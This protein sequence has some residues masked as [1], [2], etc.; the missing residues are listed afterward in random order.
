LACISLAAG[1]A[2]GAEEPVS[3]FISTA[4]SL[5]RAEDDAALA[6]HIEQHPLLVGAAVADLLDRAARAPGSFAGAPGLARRIARYY[7][8]AGG[9]LTCLSLVETFASWSP[10]DRA[11]RED[12]RVQH[13]RAD[14]LRAS[15]PA[16]ALELY[17]QIIP[18]YES[19]G[20][21]HAIA[22]AWGGI[23]VAQWYLG[24]LGQVQEA[25][26][27]ALAARRAVEDHILEGKTLNG[28]GSVSLQTGRLSEAVR[29]YS[30]AIALRRRTGDVSGLGTSLTYLG[31]AYYKMGRLAD[32]REE[33]L[34][35]LP[36]LE[37][38]GSPGQRVDLLNG[39][40]NCDSE[41][42]RYHRANERYREAAEIARAAGALAKEARCRV[43]LADSYQRTGR[44]ARALA[45]LDRVDSLVAV[46]HDPE[47]PAL[48]HSTRGQIN[49]DIGAL[50][51]ARGDFLAGVE[52]AEGL[53]DPRHLMDALINLAFLYG[54]LGAT[55]RGLETAERA[56]ALAEKHGN[57]R[58]Y[59]NAVVIAANLLYRAGDAE[60]ALER[61]E[62]AL[63]LDRFEKMAAQVLEDRISIA[64]I[65]AAL[66]RP[67][68]SQQLFYQLAPEVTTPRLEVSFHLGL[69]H[70]FERLD[71][72]SATWHYEKALSV[73]EDSR[74]QLG[75]GEARSSFLSGGRR[76]YFEE[77][78]RYYATRDDG[79]DGPW[80]ER[81]FRTIER[82]KARGLLELM[83]PA[84]ESDDAPLDR[85]NVQPG[86][87]IATVADVRVGLPQGAAMLQYALGD[88]AS[89]LWVVDEGGHHLEFLPPRRRIATAV[90]QFRDAVRRPGAG[91]PTLRAA[92]RSLYDMLV[93]PVAR[94]LEN[95]E[96]VVIVPDGLL[97]GVP[98]D[99]LLT[100]DSEG[101]WRTQPFLG[102]EWTTVYSPSA[103]VYFQ[104]ANNEVGETSPYGADLVALGD[105]EFSSPALAPLP[106][107]RAEVGA[108]AEF[109]DA[110]RREVW[111]GGEAT[112]AR[113][114]D[115]LT[116]VHPR[117]LHFATHGI[118]DA[119][120]PQR[121]EIVLCA[122]D[123]GRFDGHL[124]MDE[125][126]ATSGRAGLVVLSACESGLGKVS[127]GEG[128]IGLSRA[129]I[130]AGCGGTVASLWPVADESTGRLM[131]A[132][133]REML[134]AQQPAARAMRSA[135]LSLLSD[136]TYAH[137]FYWSPFIVVGDGRTPW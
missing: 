29:F 89:M 127:R 12:A 96:L 94:R 27:R 58:K 101:G 55:Q 5:S 131:E 122:D 52:A 16:R 133:Y 45:A 28:L 72:D 132:F 120:D 98:F 115:A 104:L 137:P 78:A 20:D 21:E 64:S 1:S 15:Q 51:D 7:A 83:G 124:R 35:A 105:P 44:Y 128:V 79:D 109:A 2:A 99:A 92:L 77:V 30:D 107:A 91:D 119:L 6:R 70:S 59:R 75:M 118:I 112:E 106:F 102:R 3:G 33:Y 67:A 8:D 19:L 85:L 100:G 126:A 39:I 82:A 22:L 113:A 38:A 10:E 76:Y 60:Q 134:G 80:S 46:V 26:E 81:A 56:R 23:G 116:T 48:L 95:V 49:V 135:R 110:S 34:K 62:K 111:V 47:L 63:A 41:M 66:D 73:V 103:S 87:A 121:S 37:Q 97:H 25:Y 11:R 123:K 24:D 18:V 13:D 117:V 90:K 125:I 93:E 136:E 32:A 53:S 14:S 50:D 43:N 84:G 40:A 68:E 69:A 31:H 36:L 108:I 88:T 9:S 17:H 86:N 4:D 129:F 42:G 130:A 65:L 61:W 71:P 57:T 54:E 114:H 74:T